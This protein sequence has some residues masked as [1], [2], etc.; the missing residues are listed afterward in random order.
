M[1]RLVK[2]M[3]LRDLTITYGMT[4]TSPA[5]VMSSTFDSLELRC[6]TVGRVLPHTQVRIVDPHHPLYPSPDTPSVPVGVTGELWSAGYALQKGYW[7]NQAETDKCMFFDQEG[8]RW[9]MTGDQ[10]LMNS[11]GFISIVGRI[12]DIIIRGGENLFPVVIENRALMMEGVADCSIV[13]VADAT[14]G[15][16]VGAFVQRDHSSQGQ[17]LTPAS[18]RSH[19]ANLLSHQSAPDWVW[20]LGEQ[21]VEEEYP[22]T[23]SGKIRKVELRG[24]AEDLVKKGVGKARD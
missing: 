11:E 3:N 20:F 13:A 17:S 22:K 18:I 1:R 21:G 9:I 5:T 4:E 24:W 2:R 12:K 8:L 10:A 23:A 7:N 6:T 15:E 16:V 19:I 14:M